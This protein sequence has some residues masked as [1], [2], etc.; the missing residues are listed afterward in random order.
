MAFRGV[1]SYLSCFGSVMIGSPAPRQVDT[2]KVGNWNSN[3]STDDGENVGKS[4]G[5][6]GRISIQGVLCHA[7]TGFCFASRIF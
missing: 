2:W 7:V 3:E 5:N 6:L 4:V 1:R